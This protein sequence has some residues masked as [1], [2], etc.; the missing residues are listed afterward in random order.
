MDLSPQ[1]SV[2]RPKASSHWPLACGER[3]VPKGLGPRACLPLA[4]SRSFHLDSRDSHPPTPLPFME[5]KVPRTKGSSLGRTVTGKTLLL[6]QHPVPAPASWGSQAKRPVPS[7]NS[8]LPS[9]GYPEGHA[10]PGSLFKI[11]FSRSAKTGAQ[12]LGKTNKVVNIK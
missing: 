12:P 2:T 9:Q 11:F 8:S 3:P 4:C 5:E 10:E 1:R 7:L 6:R